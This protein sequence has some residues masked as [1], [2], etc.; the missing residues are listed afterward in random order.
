MPN[1]RA[2]NKVKIGAW[3]DRLDAANL[4][5][6]AASQGLHVSTLIEAAVMK[7]LPMILAEAACSLTQDQ[8]QLIASAK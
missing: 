8:G 5:Q 7:S 6:F 1:V 3:V 4:R 2:A